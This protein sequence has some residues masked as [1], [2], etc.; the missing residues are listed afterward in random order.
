VLLQVLWASLSVYICR[1]WA[2]S[3]N[4]CEIFLRCSTKN[5]QEIFPG[6]LSNIQRKISITFGPN[7][8]DISISSGGVVREKETLYIWNCWKTCWKTCFS[9]ALSYFETK[10][11]ISKLVVIK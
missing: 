4:I 3:E 9:N 2:C 6:G 8:R 7:I 1:D 11:F 10:S 5:I